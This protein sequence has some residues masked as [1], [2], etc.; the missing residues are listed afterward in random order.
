[1]INK[2]NLLGKTPQELGD[3]DAIH[4][5]IAAVRAAYMLMPGQH[6]TLNDEREAVAASAKQSHGVADPFRKDP[7]LR[8]DVFWMLLSQDQVPN[9]QHVWEHPK[10][11][12]SPP[13]KPPSRNSTLE[14]AAKELGISYDMLMDACKY[15]VETGNPFPC[16]GPH[17]TP[18]KLEAAIERAELH[19]IFSAWG[20][21]T[22][23]EFDNHGSDC[24]PE[25]DYPDQLLTLP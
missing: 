11:D 4:V 25:Y 19:E 9:V 23:H 8:G 3:K 2:K 15:A 17:N 14:S 12:F 16:T 7:I 21:E 20:D 1:M 13:K 24:C 5:A 10:L 22:G 18:E 6:I